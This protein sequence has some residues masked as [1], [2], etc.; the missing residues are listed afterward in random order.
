MNDLDATAAQSPWDRLPPRLRPRE[1]E[2]RGSGNQWLIETTLL[3]LVGLLLAVATITDV[4]RQ[5]HVNDRL[6][7][8]LR[9]WRAYTGHDYHNLSIEQELRAE[10]TSAS[11]RDTVCG[12]TEPGPPGVRTQICLQIAGPT[13]AGRREVLGGWYLPPESSDIRE[14]RY[15]CFGPS[16]AGLCAR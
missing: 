8:D 1:R 2:L 11:K 9:T 3:V 15:R 7:A 13:R 5:V 6:T 10:T 12:N 4:G 16:T 14:H